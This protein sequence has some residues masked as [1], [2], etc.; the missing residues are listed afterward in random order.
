M[1][2]NVIK[3]PRHQPS[4]VFGINPPIV[5]AGGSLAFSLFSWYKARLRGAAAKMQFC[6]S[7][8][9]IEMLE[10][11]HVIIFDLQM[12]IIFL[13]ITDIGKQAFS[14]KQHS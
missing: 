8:N 12:H 11:S 4:E 5:R 7:F 3:D 6:R 13:K 1:K 14:Q 2:N 9:L 10:F